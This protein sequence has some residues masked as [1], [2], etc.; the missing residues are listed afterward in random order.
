MMPRPL[1]LPESELLPLL[2]EAIRA[3]VFSKEFLD[4]LQEE[5]T[6]RAARRR[7]GGPPLLRYS[8]GW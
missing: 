7:R 1:D 5:L 8:L 3:G 6:E 2:R 4:A